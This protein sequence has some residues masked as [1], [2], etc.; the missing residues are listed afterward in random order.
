[1]K[2]PVSLYKQVYT[3]PENVGTFPVPCDVYFK[4]MSGQNG[5]STYAHCTSATVWWPQGHSSINHPQSSK[6]YLRPMVVAQAKFG[7]VTFG[8]S[9]FRSY[10]V[11]WIFL[12]SLTETRW[13]DADGLSVF[14]WYASIG[15]HI[16]LLQSSIDLKLTPQVTWGSNLILA[17]RAKKKIHVSMCLDERSPEGVWFVAPTFF[18]QMLYTKTI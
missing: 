13:S 16:D 9:H 10:E 14:S 1:M 3:F 7:S 8:Q 6:S 18:V 5:D 17:F 2:L 12:Y 4:T 15:M 11:A